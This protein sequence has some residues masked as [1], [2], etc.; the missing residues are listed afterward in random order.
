MGDTVTNWLGSLPGT[1]FVGLWSGL[2]VVILSVALLLQFWLAVRLLLDRIQ[3][4]DCRQQPEDTEEIPESGVIG[5]CAG[6]L[7]KR[8][9]KHMEGSPETIEQLLGGRYDRLLHWVS[10][11]RASATTV[12]LLFTFIGLAFALYQ[13]SNELNR[14]G[15]YNDFA[16]VLENVRRALPGMST[17]FASSIGG[18]IV[19]LLIGSISSVLEGWRIAIGA[20][21]A[22]LSAEWLEPLLSP[23]GGGNE[24]YHYVA[25]QTAAIRTG[26]QDLMAELR[27]DRATQIA[28]HRAVAD[29][30]GAMRQTLQEVNGTNR[31]LNLRAEALIAAVQGVTEGWRTASKDTLD[32]VETQHR[33][34]MDDYHH[35]M[36][37]ASTTVTTTLA[38]A[39]KEWNTVV[40]RSRQELEASF[41]EIVL[42]TDTGLGNLAAALET[43]R[44]QGTET[45]AQLQILMKALVEN[46]A[47]FGRLTHQVGRDLSVGAQHVKGLRE[48]T[49]TFQKALVRTQDMINETE[50]RQRDS[51]AAV[52]KALDQVPILAHAVSEAAAASARATVRLEQVVSGESME[53]YLENIPHLVQLSESEVKSRQAL[54]AAVGSF[55]EVAQTLDRL[56]GLVIRIGASAEGMAKA[57]EDIG[58]ALTSV[59]V[60]ELSPA[61]AAVVRQTATE[62]VGASERV[63]LD[64]HQATETTVSS[65]LV[66]LH[67]E[68]MTVVHQQRQLLA[69]FQRPAWERIFR[70][71]DS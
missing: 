47:E 1:P 48:A 34:V 16:T 27:Q 6:V 3:L 33:R 18:L 14:A 61:V 25:E 50:Q 31:I 11:L 19:A 58:V 40:T 7:R 23:P 17:A 63:W 32:R 65:T 39:N 64:R 41:D 60:Q 22:K 71:D 35:A 30:I 13:L 36:E 4:W 70:R 52:R 10:F 66:K 53:H 42:A 20:Q 46:A 44:T 45:I 43:V 56:N 62:V 67:Q 49:E 2:L 68:M 28:A 55:K 9:E 59:A 29:A 21:M 8:A 38:S 26:F 12:G 5:L 15:S 69:W 57:L 24:L 54:A 37:T 51:Q